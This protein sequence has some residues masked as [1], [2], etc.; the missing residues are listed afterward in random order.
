MEIAT[1]VGQYNTSYRDTAVEANKTYWYRVRA[2]NALGD[3]PYS[4]TVSVSLVP[5][6][7]PYSLT[8]Y[9]YG[10]YVYLNWYES[11]YSSVAGYKIERAPDN[12]GTPGTWTEIAVNVG[13]YYNYYSDYG[14]TSGTNW[15]LVR[16]YNVL[17]DSDYS[18][19][20]NVSLV[21]PAAPYSLTASVYPSYVYLNWYESNSSS[22]VGY[23][24]ERAEDNGGIPGTWTEIATNFGAYYTYYYDYGVTPSTNYW[25]R[26]RAYNIIG[27]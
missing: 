17:G 11:D 8:A 7:A 21:P 12:G 5:P 25:Y 14:A 10:S 3:S 1:N 13:P 9:F 18:A 24:I 22:V 4:P 2:Y 19:P 6:A 16:A 23:K 26:V 27:D 15:Y 20:I